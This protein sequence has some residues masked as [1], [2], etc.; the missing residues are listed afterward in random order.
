MSTVDD[1]LSPDGVLFSAPLSRLVTLES[2]TS[3]VY[4]TYMFRVMALHL[5]SQAST[6]LTVNMSRPNFLIVSAS[7]CSRV[8]GIDYSG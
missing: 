2:H 7:K 8:D 5:C 6:D 3:A 4:C 1:V